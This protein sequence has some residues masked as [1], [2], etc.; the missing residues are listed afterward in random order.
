MNLHGE[1]LMEQYKK[2]IP[3]YK[4]IEEIAVDAIKRK[5]AETGMV[6]DSVSS[7]IKTEESLEG[8]LNLKGDKYNTIYEITDLVGVRVVTYYNDDVDKVAA[9]VEHTFKID[10]ENSIDKRTARSYDSFG[11]MSLHFICRVPKELYFDPEK[12]EINNVP[13]ELQMRTGLQNVWAMIMHDN[14][15]KSDIEIPKD[16]F[17]RFSRLSGLL[18]IA[19]A[20]FSSIRRELSEYRRKTLALIREKKF[21]EIELDGET[22]Q[23]YLKLEPFKNLNE[24]IASINN[25]EIAKSDLMPY[26]PVL[27]DLDCKTLGDVER[28]VKDYSDDAYSLALYQLGATDLDIILETIGV[29]NLC[30]VAL[31]K[32]DYGEVGIRQFLLLINPED[33]NAKRKAAN[34]YRQACKAGIIGE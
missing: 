32:N 34:I 28:M 11:Y 18:E 22:F 26:L 2:N 6:V 29:R 14:G 13:I 5:L 15:Y 8:K 20:E 27:Q 12:P 3:V 33:K 21:D 25:A 7:R 1:L 10:R 16:Y 19:D 23:Q 31:L 17:R 9:L 30:I 24:K 4:K